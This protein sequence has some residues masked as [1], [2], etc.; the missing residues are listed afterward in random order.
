LGHSEIAINVFDIK[1]TGSCG[2]RMGPLAHLQRICGKICPSE[3]R[4]R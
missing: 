1:R 3:L 4:N 2:V